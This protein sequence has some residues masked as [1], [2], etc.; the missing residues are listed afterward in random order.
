MPDL[1]EIDLSSILEIRKAIQAAGANLY[2]TSPPGFPKNI[3]GEFMSLN[4]KCV[5]YETNVA[6]GLTVGCEEILK[7]GF[8]KNQRDWLNDLSN[9]VHEKI[10]LRDRL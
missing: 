2:N 7:T 10:F 6:G 4:E 9:T 8:T 5:Y 1:H 3:A